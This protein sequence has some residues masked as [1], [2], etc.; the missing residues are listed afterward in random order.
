MRWVIKTSLDG[1]YCDEFSRDGVPVIPDE[2]ANLMLPTENGV[3]VPGVVAKV[4]INQSRSPA[5]LRIL[6]VSP[7]K[8]PENEAERLRRRKP[9]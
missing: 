7:G 1:A 4:Q 9:R 3:F 2:G 6:C 8:A 5:V